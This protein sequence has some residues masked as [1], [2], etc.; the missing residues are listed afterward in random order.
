MA[1]VGMEPKI[2]IVPLLLSAVGGESAAH[3]LFHAGFDG[4]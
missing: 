1:G 3:V 4:Q 2:Q